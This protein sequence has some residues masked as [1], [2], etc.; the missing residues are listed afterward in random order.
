MDSFFK[1]FMHINKKLHTVSAIIV[2]GPDCGEKA[3]WA[4][5]KYIYTS[6][7]LPLWNDLK[8]HLKDF[9]SAA[10]VDIF[11]STVFCETLSGTPNMIICGCG[12]V[13]IPVITLGNT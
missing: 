5:G 2:S 4:D 9:H 13:S 7:E 3:L 11:G 12:H 1:Q 6:K 8:L 10:L